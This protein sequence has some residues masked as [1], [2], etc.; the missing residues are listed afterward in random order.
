MNVKA[1]GTRGSIAISN[2]DSIEAGGNTTCFEVMSKCLPE[3]MRL[4]ID[5]GTGFVPAGHY[6]LSEIGSKQLRYLM[7]FTHYHYDHI[8]GLTL[9]PPTF[10]EQLPMI[11]YGPRDTG[12]GPKE[13]INKLFDRPRFPIDDKKIIHKM[14]F[15][16]LDDFDVHTIAI[17]PKGGIKTFKL[18]IFN[19]II[20]KG[21]QLPLIGGNYSLNECLLIKMVKTNHGNATC[22]SYRFEE[23]PTG[24]VFVLCTDHEDMVGIPMELRRHFQDADLLIMDAQYSDEKYNDPVFCTAGFGLVT[25]F[26]CVKQAV[27]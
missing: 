2:A 19:T 17:H 23:R 26:G 18:D 13:T 4:M 8:L 27:V 9:A 6:Y 22:I 14:T 15:K 21:T 24:K 10:I 5:A 3:G 20:N 16:S 12:D 7:F 11:L 1:W 25:P